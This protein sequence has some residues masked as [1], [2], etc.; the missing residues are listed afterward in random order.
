MPPQPTVIYGAGGHAREVGWL[1]D[2]VNARDSRFRI[3]GFLDDAPES[4]GR[5]LNDRPVLGG[6]DWIERCDEDRLAV[7]LGIGSPGAKYRVVQR[8]RPLGVEFPV[9]VHPDV[10]MSR[11]VELGEGTTI[12]YGCSLTVDIEL[13]AFVFLNRHVTVGHD[14]RIGSYANLNPR[15]VVSGNDTLEQ[16]VDVGTGAVIIQQLSIG[17][18]TVVGAGA[19]V[20][21]DLPANVTAVGVPARPIKEHPDWRTR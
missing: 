18:G 19:S 4:H 8:L 20:V 3:L 7:V 16:G 2:A 15:V 14:A 9:V 13:G 17:E 10:P 11:W 12:T 1:L 5:L 6:A 21:D